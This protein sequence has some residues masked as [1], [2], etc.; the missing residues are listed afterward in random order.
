M[1][2]VYGNAFITIAAS[3]GNSVDDGIFG[4]REAHHETCYKIGLPFE[5][6]GRNNIQNMVYV[7]QIEKGMREYLGVPKYDFPASTSLIA[8][9]NRCIAGPGVFRNASFLVAY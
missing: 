4:P 1:A 7:S 6:N 9:M 8:W 3:R 5:I 2:D